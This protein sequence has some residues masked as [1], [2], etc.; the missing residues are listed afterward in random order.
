MAM[1]TVN[2]SNESPFKE[3]YANE[4]SKK[5]A[6]LQPNIAAKNPNGKIGEGGGELNEDLKESDV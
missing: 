5:K 1:P 2:R 3:I 6:F 4:A